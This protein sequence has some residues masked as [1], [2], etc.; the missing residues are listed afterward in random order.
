ME[1]PDACADAVLKTFHYIDLWLA[2][3]V[4]P[5][6]CELDEQIRLRNVTWG[7]YEEARRVALRRLAKVLHPELCEVDHIGW[8]E[9][10]D[11]NLDWVSG[12][13]GKEPEEPI[14]VCDP[15]CNRGLMLLDGRHRVVAARMDER[16]TL[17]AVFVS[18]RYVVL[19]AH[20]WDLL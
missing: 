3:D 20:F 4:E 10:R 9:T 1:A 18:R 8:F 11:I 5:T 6:D 16:T 12:L 13:R 7:R 14:V 2:G 19:W 17:S 15:A